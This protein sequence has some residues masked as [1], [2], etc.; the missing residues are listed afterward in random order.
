MHGSLELGR[1][2]RHRRWWIPVVLVLLLVAAGPRLAA[3]LP[4]AVSGLDHALARYILPDYEARLTRL[5]QENADLHARLAQTADALAE[6]QAL[7]QL[8]DCGRVTGSWQPA[9][10]VARSVG[11]ITLA[12]S[13]A[14]GTPLLDAGGRYA[15]RV[16]RDLGNDTCEAVLAGHENSPCAGLCGQAAGLLD[17]GGGW[18][19]TGLPADSGL[20]AGDVVTTPG[21]YWLGT[22]AE[23]PQPETGGLTAWAPLTDTADLDS[24]VFFVKNS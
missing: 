22:L 5:Q 16:N 19:L 21:G 11:K 7:R 13:A 9:R 4:A 3:A 20:Q 1:P 15:G 14:A 17:T 24:T 8:L 6:N 18:R 10:V 12:C 23:A 2:R